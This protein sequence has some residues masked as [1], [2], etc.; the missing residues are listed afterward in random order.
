VNNDT[1]T[2]NININIDLTYD[3]AQV[4]TER[5]PKRD[6]ILHLTEE[7]ARTLRSLLMALKEPSSEYYTDIMQYVRRL[8][9][10]YF[11]PDIDQRISDALA[12]RS[13]P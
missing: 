12:E 1:R 4:L 13:R 2:L 6:I 5:T 9:H 8:R 10:D 7:E 11:A 3:E